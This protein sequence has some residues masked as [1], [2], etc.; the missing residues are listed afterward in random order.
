MLDDSLIAEI[1]AFFDQYTAAFASFR[2][3][4]IAALYYAPTVTMRG[5]GSIHCL[6]SREE[7]A[8]FFQGVVDTYRKDGYADSRFLDL[9]VAPIGD[10]SVLTTMNWEMLRGDGSLIRRW[11]QSYNLVRVGQGW[12]I[13]VSTFHLPPASTA[14]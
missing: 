3:D 1:R 4:Q 6:Q 12:Q 13:L 14:A 5:D 10:R 8:R 11:R 2:G 9:E 7:L